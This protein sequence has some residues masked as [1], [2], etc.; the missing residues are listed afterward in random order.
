MLKRLLQFIFLFSLPLFS[1]QT[2]VVEKDT[3]PNSTVLI[4][5]SKD[6][7][8]V[9]D[10]TQN[11]SVTD[12][13]Q[14]NTKTKQKAEG[15]EKP[16]YIPYIKP[17]DRVTVDDYKMFFMDGTQKSVDTTLSLAGEYTFNFLR[18]DYFEYLPL[19]NMGEGFN[20]LG[21]DFHSAQVT[22]QM[23]AQVKHFGYFEKEDI[24]YFEVPS[25]YTELFFKSTFQQ[26]QHLDATLAINTSP[27]FNVA[28]S[29]KGF[30]SLGKYTSAL[31]RSR[32]FRMSTQYQTYNQKYRLRLHQTTQS[33]ENEVNGGLTNDANYFFEN[34]PNY[35]LADEQGQA[36][37][38][39]NGEQQ[40]IF[41]DGF[42]D[43]SRLSTQ[44]QGQ[45][46][47]EGKRYFMEH[48]V[49]F[50]PIAK[51]TTAYKMAMGLRSSYENKNYQYNQSRVNSY[52]GEAY[53]SSKVADSTQNSTLE[54]N[55]FLSL[56]NKTFG[57]LQFDVYHYQ[58]KNTLLA[59]S[60]EKDTLQNNTRLRI[61]QL[62]VKGH[63]KGAILGTKAS[64]EY[65]QSLASEFASTS[66][67]ATV[68]RP[69]L[70]NLSVSGEYKYR[71]QPLNFNFYRFQSDF[72]N[73]NWDNPDLV[74]PEVSTKS[75]GLSHTK[76][77]RIS[78]HWN[79]LNHYAF[80]N[81]AT[82]LR[83]LN[84]KF[85]VE[86]IQRELPIEYFKARFDQQL[87]FGK[88]TWANNVQY[89]KVD[90]IKANA[91][92]LLSDPQALNVPEWLI[93]STLMLT[94]DIFKKALFFQSGMTFVF[95]TDYYADQYNPL[96]A[97][98]VTQNNTKIGEYPRVDF[99][100]NAKIQ[101]SRIYFKIENLSGPVEHLIKPDTPYDYYA[102]PFVPY[103]DFSIRFGL[104]WNFFD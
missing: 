90:Q 29:F 39:E 52:F 21:Y 32:Q 27:K 9:K 51:D 71:S 67:R 98:F 102:A 74:N 33:L 58:W 99:F 56:T 4:S 64:A 12:T 26:G 41:Y 75:L 100:F 87:N 18:K 20:K 30:R 60:Y 6:S 92:E 79:T 68:V 44:I 54:N 91:D 5:K 13:L 35:V 42:L 36:V 82:R 31:S 80:F 104:I 66:W 7:L 50:Y 94:S 83:D 16:R 65:Y 81:N 73:Y 69:L 10:L 23:G 1:Q 76:W 48:R 62:A 43:R 34:A 55:L 38:D 47:L 86:I 72:I 57:D 45:N 61:N 25:A 88:F 49:Q 28:V 46:E 11:K 85:E 103:R 95:F 96:L 53:V 89:Q 37:L 97:E 78:A 70:F 8:A 101:S 77:G 17:M 3:V 84:K 24:P 63:W 14:K 22:P 40:F 15:E 2:N 19:P 59:K 93:R